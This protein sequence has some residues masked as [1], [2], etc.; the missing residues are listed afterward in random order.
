[1]RASEKTLR[2]PVRRR[3]GI[4]ALPSRSSDCGSTRG[5]IVG[6]SLFEAALGL[7]ISFTLSLVFHFFPATQTTFF[8]SCELTSL[9]VWKKRLFDTSTTVTTAT[10]FTRST[11]SVG[12]KITSADL[13][14]MTRLLVQ[15]KSQSIS[16]TRGESQTGQPTLL[17]SNDEYT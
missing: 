14:T 12:Q 4:W 3:L 6:Q 8:N 7:L 15:M 11:P 17:S 9:Q 10:T 5:Q 16:I 13:D 2:E 1:M